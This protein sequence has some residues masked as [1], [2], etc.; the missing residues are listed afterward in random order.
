MKR[1]TVDHSI[2]KVVTIFSVLLLMIT[3]LVYASGNENTKTVPSPNTKKTI[4]LKNNQKTFSI[5]MNANRKTGYQWYIKKYQKKLIT[6]V[7]A[8]Y[9]APKN[10]RP[11]AGGHSVWTF[12]INPDAFVVPRIM[13]IGFMYARAWNLNKADKVHY[14]IITTG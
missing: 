6:P 5:T 14:Y 8:E 2:K 12:N 7:S 13:K 1:H 4:I 9:R 11:G 10:M 3:Q